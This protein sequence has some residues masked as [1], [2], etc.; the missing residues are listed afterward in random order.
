MWLI[1]CCFDWLIGYHGYR[2]SVLLL[3]ND[4][5][6]GNDEEICHKII[7]N[8]K[9]DGWK[10]GKSQ[11]INNDVMISQSSFTI[12]Y[13]Q[14]LLKPWHKTEMDGLLDDYE[15]NACTIQRGIVGAL[16]LAHVLYLSTAAFRRHSSKKKAQRRQ[17]GVAC[18]I[19]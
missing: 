13:T 2:Y 15:S 10:I 19:T 12:V 14:L 11:V 16:I 4:G 3:D 8:A 18:L 17:V 5:S 6:V 1:F 7:A 9:L